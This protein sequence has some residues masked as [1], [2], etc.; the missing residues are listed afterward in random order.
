MFLPAVIGFAVILVSFDHVESADPLPLDG[1]GRYRLRDQELCRPKCQQ[2][3]SCVQSGIEMP[4]C[5][6]LNCD[7][8]QCGD[9]QMCGKRLWGNL[10]CVKKGEK[11]FLMES[12]IRLGGVQNNPLYNCSAHTP[13]EWAEMNG[14]K[15]PISGAFTM[16][17][18]IVIMIIYIMCLIVIASKELIHLSC[19]KIM[20]LLGVVDLCAI[21]AGSIISGYFL[22]E[23]AVFCTHPDI[24]YPIGSLA[25]AAWCTACM[26]CLILVINRILDILHPSLGE[27]YFKGEIISRYRTNIILIFPILYGSYFFFFTPTVAFSSR[28]QAWFFDPFL[29]NNSDPMLYANV[30]HTINNFSIVFLTCFLYGF[31]CIALYLKSRRASSAAG[32]RSHKSST[33]MCMINMIASVIYVLMQ[34]IPVPEWLI[35]VAEMTWQVGHG[36]PAVIY[37]SLNRTI[38]TGV[39]RLL[40]LKKKSII[41]SNIGSSSNVMITN[42]KA[43]NLSSAREL[44]DDFQ[45]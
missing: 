31:L 8:I 23:G 32:F 38:R 36:A 40:G 27:M 25:V 20:F 45:Y 6:Q 41:P 26:I 28:Y 17:Y 29:F 14:E 11:N 43:T 37:I 35:I 1:D 12:V 3:E 24:M 19:Y 18:G 39:L 44:T 4:N 10:V 5:K 13:E 16:A 22:I 21:F 30:P 7:Q 2:R 9:D 33:L 15:H 42:S 34:F